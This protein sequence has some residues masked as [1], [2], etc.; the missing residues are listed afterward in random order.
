M[1][2]EAIVV[3]AASK[4]Y[5]DHPALRGVSFRVKAGEAVGYLGPNGAGKS[6]TLRLLCGLTRPNEGEVRVLGLDPIRDHDGALRKV[7][8]LVETP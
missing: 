8:V 5:G 3:T 2:P 1:P 4:R 7:G 6:T